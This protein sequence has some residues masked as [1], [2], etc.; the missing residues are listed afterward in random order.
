M[1]APSSPNLRT[2]YT[3]E[4]IRDI[5][6]HYKLLAELDDFLEKSPLTKQLLSIKYFI[7]RYDE[8]FKRHQP[9]DANKSFAQILKGMQFPVEKIP[10]SLMVGILPYDDKTIVP[11]HPIILDGTCTVDYSVLM[12]FWE[13]KKSNWGINPFTGK[14]V[15]T[16]EYDEKL[17]AILTSLC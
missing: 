12:Q 10:E 8:I 4:P 11:T 16:M 6:V 15:K 3:C 5:S 7:K 14:A 1:M 2:P 13:Y 9:Q 17:K